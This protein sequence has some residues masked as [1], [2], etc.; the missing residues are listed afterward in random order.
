MS[1]NQQ[2]Q[3]AYQLIRQGN[4]QEAMRILVPIVKADA[5]NADAWWLLANAVSDTNQARRALEQVLR[6]RPNDD[7]AR[8]MLDRLSGGSAGSAPSA[9]PSGAA[10]GSFSPSSGSSPFGPSS[11]GGGLRPS[12]PAASPDPFGSSDPFGAPTAS[13][14]DPF[15]AADPF[16]APGSGS[17]DPFG[18]PAGRQRGVQ[19]QPDFGAYPPPKP[20]R[21]NGCRNLLLGCGVIALLCIGICAGTI[22]IAGAQVR[23][24]IEQAATQNPQIGGPILSIFG[25]I[26][27]GNT[28]DPAALNT[29]A[30]SGFGITSGS[31]FEALGTAAAGGDLGQAFNQA[32]TQAATQGL[33][34]GALASGGINSAIGSPL[35]ANLN[36]AGTITIGGSVNGMVPIGGAPQGYTFNGEL[37]TQVSIAAIA[38]NNGFDT[39]LALYGPDDR[40]VAYNDDSDASGEGYNSR[41]DFT[42]PANGEYTIVVHSFGGVSG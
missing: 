33:N 32:L 3:Q 9:S 37:G 10:R 25:S 41:I 35:P 6:L 18:A 15:G 20:K 4:K 42:L 11:A 21:S 24:L 13:S 36:N 23:N 14:G 40:L 19:P 26:L 38:Q 22:V 39:V 8:R 27:Q 17:S 31:G 1:T 7:K 16:G 30:A 12:A 29:L 34:L 2:L 5:N 28:P